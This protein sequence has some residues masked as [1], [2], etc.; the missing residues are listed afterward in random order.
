MQVFKY[1]FKL[2]LSM[3]G[4][5]AIFLGTFTFAL[6]AMMLQLPNDR[7]AF[8]AQKP[9]VAIFNRDTSVFSSGLTSYLAETTDSIAIDDTDTAR[10]EAIYFQTVDAIYII[11]SQF[12]DNFFANKNPQIEVVRGPGQGAAQADALISNYMRLAE[13]R[14]LAGIGQQETVD[15]VADDTNKHIVVS[16][17]TK[18]NINEIGKA[19]YFMN[20]LV[21]IILGLNITVI[22]TIMLLFNN[23]S[24]RRRNLIGGLSASS[25]NRQLIAAN[26][27][28]SLGIWAFFMV[29]A[30]IMYPHVMFS[31]HGVLY[32][33]GALLFSLIGLAIGFAIG[34]FVSNRRV[35]PGITN[36]LALGMSFLCGVFVPL[37]ILGESVLNI[38]RFL[39]AYWYIVANEHIA[40]LTDFT[41]QSLQPIFNEWLIIIAFVIGIFAVT[42]IINRRRKT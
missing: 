1:Y 13:I 18:E 32:A 35:V 30:T 6:I 19:M 41:M 22:S 27:V 16:T 36:V 17:R 9:N 15:G 14:M 11:P 25:T 42:L 7:A 2:A 39:P 33:T 21:Y 8:T 28:F 4:S 26:T 3:K 38:S 37:A 40:S 29:I 10:K 23:P 31:A 20:T 5:I 24:I 34:T 12:G